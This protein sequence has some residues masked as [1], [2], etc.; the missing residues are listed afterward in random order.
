M[1][2][3]RALIAALSVL[4]AALLLASCGSSDDS[5]S[6]QVSGPAS[7]APAD[8][9][10]YVEATL[11]PEGEQRANAEAL[12]SELG[13]VPLLGSQLEPRDLAD[14]A[15]QAFDDAV[16]ADV[17]YAEDVEPWLG[18]KAGL[19]VTGLPAGSGTTT[20]TPPSY[21]LAVETTDDSVARDS[22]ARIVEGEG[23]TEKEYDGV[24]YFESANGIYDTGVLDGMLVF[25]NG[26]NFEAA[27]DAAHSGDSLAASDDYEQAFAPLTEVGLGSAYVDFDRFAELAAAEDPAGAADIEKARGVLPE[28]FE[29]PLAAELVAGS[30]SLALDVSMPQPGEDPLEIDATSLLA[31]APPDSYAAVGLAGVGG[32]AET[33]IARLEKTGEAIDDPTLRSGAIDGALQSGFGFG[34]DDLAGAFGDGI[35]YAT[36]ELGSCGRSAGGR[37]GR[38]RLRRAGEV[39]RR[40]EEDGLRIDRPRPGARPAARA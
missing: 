16:G 27:V 8:T 7:F 1:R 26:G 19:A 3:S 37:H 38:F 40:A 12:L 35:A 2:R 22:L 10:L 18:S 23:N 4:V 39:R 11:K 33:V 34:T 17:D 24:S 9:P 14:Q 25:A 29:A 6:P 13:S 15:V 31:D 5:G 20:D 21:V 36:G 30:G 28:L 32:I